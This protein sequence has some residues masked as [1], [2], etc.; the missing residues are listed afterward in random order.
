MSADAT[1]EVGRDVPPL[2]ISTIGT[3][4]D[5]DTGPSTVHEGLAHGL[6]ERGHDID[7]FAW[8]GR[9]THPHPRVTAHPV[10]ERTESVAG[11]IEAHESALES[12]RNTNADLVHDLEH[13]SPG[14]EVALVQWTATPAELATRGL[15]GALRPLR[16]TAGDLLLNRHRR[17]AAA[18]AAVVVASSPETAR[19]MRRYWRITPDHTLPLGIKQQDLSPPSGVSDPPRVLLPGR[20]SAKKGQAAVLDHLDPDSDRMQVDIVGAIADGDYAAC[21]DGWRSHHHGFV[22]RDRLHEYYQGAD[23]TVVPSRH[24]NFGLTALEAMARGCAVVALNSVGMTRFE[25]ANEGA[26]VF[27]SDRGQ[28]AA[29]T[30]ERLADNPE[31]LEVS[32]YSAYQT[33][34]KFTWRRIAAAWEGLYQCVRWQ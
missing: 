17:K 11:I 20:I 13:Q 24:E 26:G 19:Q 6:A 8:G 28:A 18:N 10:A 33:A 31:Q 23:I 5:S 3:L 16:A 32:K 22:S 14:A 12:A 30:V 7:M 27:T 25:W 21:L 2:H 1:P 34:S 4:N 15:L 9:D 29:A